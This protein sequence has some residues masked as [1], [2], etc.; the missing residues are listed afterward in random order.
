MKA[1]GTEAK[2]ITQNR[3][4]AKEY[5]EFLKDE[6]ASTID[7]DE[8]LTE[9]D[10]EAYNKTFRDFADA[11]LADEVVDSKHFSAELEEIAEAGR[12]FAQEILADAAQLPEKRAETLESIEA[13]YEPVT[14]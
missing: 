14:T 8:N 7:S 11:T 6:V 5:R 3:A 12:I 10:K 1:T 2:E 13:L 9:G 4:N